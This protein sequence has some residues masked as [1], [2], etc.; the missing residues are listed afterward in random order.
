MANISA[1]GSADIVINEDQ[2]EA[3]LCF[4]PA[5][6]KNVD[7]EAVNK[8]VTE[9]HLAPPVIP[10]KIEEFLQKAA[11]SKEPM[12]LV[13]YTGVEAVQ[14]VNEEPVWEAMPIPPDMEPFKSEILAKAA[15]PQLFRIK[16]EKIKHET[17]VKKPAALP[18]LPSKEEVVVT[19]EKQDSKEQVTV[20]PTV[21]ELFY[22]QKNVKLA[23][24]S[25]P[26]Q[27]KPGKSVF[28][29]PIQPSSQG[30]M[31]YYCG[32]GINRVGRE[33]WSMYAGF[34]RVGDNWVDILGFAKPSFEVNT[35]HDG[36]TLFLKFD[37]GDP[38]FP[39]PTAEEILAAAGAKGVPGG[40]LISAAALNEAIKKA[41]ARNE[42]IQLLSLFE[43]QAAFIHVDVTP[44]LLFAK[45]VFRKGLAGAL[46]LS[47]KDVG[48]AIKES[49]VKGYDVNALRT[50]VQAFLADPGSFELNYPLVQG[51]AAVRAKDR[52][53]KIAIPL[54]GEEET[55]RTLQRIAAFRSDALRNFTLDGVN[56][57]AMV[58]KDAKI[59]YI[60]PTVPGEQGKDIFGNILPGLPGNDPELKL[61]SG[62]E[63]HSQNITAGKSGLFLGKLTEKRFEGI[64]IES[65]DAKIA[66]SVSPDAMEAR[67]EL[68]RGSGA[69]KPL[70]AEDVSAALE[71]AKITNGLIEGAIESAVAKA[72]AEGK[73]NT[74]VAHGEPPIE[75]GGHRITWLVPIKARPPQTKDSSQHEGKDIVAGLEAA[76][77]KAKAVDKGT[78]AAAKYSSKEKE[79]APLPIAGGTAIAQ[80]YPPETE[81]RPGFDVRGTV[82]PVKPDLK[83]PELVYDS[84][85]K[86]EFRNDC[87][88]L[89]A[90]HTGELIFDGKKL[91][92]SSVHEVHGN[93]VPSAG[94]IDFSGEVRIEGKVTAGSTI[95]A[96][97][98]VFVSGLAENALISSGGKVVI[99]QGIQ[100][101]GRGIVRAK[102]SIEAG[103]AEKATLMAVED[104]KLK[105]GSILCNIKTNGKLL[106]VSETGKL[107]GGICRARFGVDL[108]NVGTEKG[109]HTEISFGQDY[110][111]KDQLDHTEAEIN[112][113]KAGLSKIDERIKQLASNQDALDKARADK[114]KLMKL[115][116]TLNLKMFTLRERFE[117]HFDS[118]V[119]IRGTIYPGVV[120]ESHNRYYEVIQARSRVIFYFDRETGRIRERSL[121]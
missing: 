118:E 36:F 102:T 18:F 57:I 97:R 111:I 55:E 108:A 114:A 99:N 32:E 85:I 74:V 112:K 53:V 116:Q 119:R 61:R 93:V 20:D 63:L 58:E 120:M 30:D 81:D 76:K 88:V 39:V 92:I 80:V 60:E 70:L 64:V 65:Q 48:Q 100:G 47:L 7:V 35:G 103:Y 26:K 27:G 11:K 42:P 22:A 8:L 62:I 105:A 104:I 95:K 5:G 115:L 113:V 49:H 86:E 17:L 68:R 41:V 38:R 33:L 75:K 52:Q 6:D 14:T 91:Q 90:N 13:L 71:A 23:T 96:G 51:K 56:S 89:I 84:S 59:A 21:K 94:I 78:A 37:P 54:F 1:K 9:A 29:K 46:P 109:N 79:D 87:K 72:V 106:I 110:L 16:T 19:W 117:E 28:G 101:Q 121:A 15:P 73:S 107:A 25:V 10:H 12:E 4:N 83:T 98:N 67:A 24:L 69:G 34:V 45:L 31:S 3:K 66:V 50:A 40:K 44:D 43:S 2:T 77:A 82:L